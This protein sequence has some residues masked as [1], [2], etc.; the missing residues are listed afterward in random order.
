MIAALRKILTERRYSYRSPLGHPFEFDLVKHP[1]GEVRI[2]IVDNC[3]FYGGMPMDG[4]STHRYFDKNRALH[5]VCI[6]DDLVPTNNYDA[7]G[8]ARYWADRTSRYIV[9]RKEFS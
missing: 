9:H 1:D 3:P 6:R 4:H 2:Y 5:Y 8:W 7:K